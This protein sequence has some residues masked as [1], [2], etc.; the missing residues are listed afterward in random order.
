MSITHLIH[1]QIGIDAHNL[2]AQYRNQIARKFGNFEKNKS[3]LIK[4]SVLRTLGKSE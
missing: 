1:T 2:L 4:V 3:S